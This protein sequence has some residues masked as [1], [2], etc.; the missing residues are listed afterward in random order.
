M[1][2]PQ[3]APQMGPPRRRHLVPLTLLAMLHTATPQYEED[4]LQY[5]EMLENGNAD[6]VELLKSTEAV[7]DY[8]YPARSYFN[9][10]QYMFEVPHAMKYAIGLIVPHELRVPLHG[11]RAPPAPPQLPALVGPAHALQLH[12][13]EE[14]GHPRHGA[15]V[16]LRLHQRPLLPL[17]D[18]PTRRVLHR[19]VVRRPK[20]EAAA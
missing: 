11:P 12:R 6:L 17:H 16:H 1:G 7:E 8:F 9:R 18:H 5:A 3:R 2:L 13:P 14:E 20:V 15:H 10:D 4:T 19:Y